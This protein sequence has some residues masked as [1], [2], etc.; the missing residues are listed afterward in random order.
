MGN[1]DIVGLAT[2]SYL[3]GLS[4]LITVSSCISYVLSIALIILRQEARIS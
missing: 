2:L 1:I 4:I 3:V